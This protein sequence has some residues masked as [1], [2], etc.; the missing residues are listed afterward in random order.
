MEIVD[1]NIILRFILDD[2]KE[3]ADKA[4]EIIENRS[5]YIL[6]EILAE[7]VYVLE[8]VYKMER[9]KISQTI[10]EFLEFDNIFIDNKEIVLTALEAYGK[11]ALDFV[12]C[13]L[14]GYSKCRNAKV[15]TF[16]KRLEKII[17]DLR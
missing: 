9:S 17:N 11:K 8:K 3:M 14:F 6:E 13:I 10:S 15:Y 7:V 12:D 1:A 4:S 16:D 5:I 2:N